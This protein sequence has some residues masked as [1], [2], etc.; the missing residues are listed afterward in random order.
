MNAITHAEKLGLR[1]LFFSLNNSWESGVCLFPITI[2][3]IITLLYI[4]TS[5]NKPVQ[6]TIISLK[7][8]NNKDNKKKYI[9]HEL[10]QE[11]KIDGDLNVR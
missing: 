2:S 7:S 4:Q 9:L 3:K 1:V 5:F 11:N 6:R 8:T 10:F